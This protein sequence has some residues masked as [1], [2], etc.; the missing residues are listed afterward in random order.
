MNVGRRDARSRIA[1]VICE[2]ATRLGVAPATGETNFPFPVTQ[3][4]LGD[5]TGLTPVHVNRTVQ[6]LRREGLA[7]VRQ[8]TRLFNWEAL[9]AAGD[10]D[11]DYLQINVKPQRRLPFA[12]AS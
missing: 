9:C 2:I 5:V 12:L 10:F 1:H 7:D 3:A 11:A 4:Q 6:A 8:N